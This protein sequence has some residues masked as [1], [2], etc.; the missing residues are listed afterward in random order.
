M[1]E[2]GV[3]EGGMSEGSESV[4]KGA[5]HG[6]RPHTRRWAD[7]RWLV[8][9]VIQANGIDWDQPRSV[10]L[11]APC[12]PEANA[13]FAALRA[14]VKKFA[15]A[16]PA[17]EAAARRRQ[18]KA[19]AAEAEGRPVTARENYFIAAILWGGA[20]W[21][22][23]EADETNHRYNKAKRECYRAYA[24]LADHRVEEVF[25]PFGDKVLP[26]W[27][28][29]PPGYTGGRLPTV[30]SIPGMDSF[31]EG[32]VSMYGDRFLSRGMAVLALDG[33][34]QYEAPLM[35]VFFSMENWIATGP[36]A[37]D[38]LAARPEVD[39]DRIALAG[40]SFG[41]F[42]GT[43]LTAH[44]PRIRACAV[45]ATCHEPGCQTIFEEASPTFKQ[46]F[47]FM[48]GMTDEAEFDVFRQSISWRGHAERIEV[49]YLCMAGEF[50][51]LSPIEHTRGLLAAL[52]GPK[53][54]LVYQ[55]SRH[56]VGGPAAANGPHPQGYMAD[57][58]AARLDG[59]PMASEEW[60][61]ESSGKVV[62]SPL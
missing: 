20:Q 6:K 4:A 35:D 12:G 53:Q 23:D 33:P 21:P 40:R 28:H 52:S 18:A 51:E 37:V 54:L 14:Q 58:I 38:W 41:S 29:L 7:Q 56:S 36:A 34:G 59:Q 55:G 1:G 22:I 42:F 10:Y 46:R 2:R 48:C 15:D 61:V 5:A 31:K 43:I 11:N 9:N 47:M 49:P 60:F 3:G 39:A 62:K 32:V 45:S 8:D 30:I 27:F 26:A 19:E 24:R 50:D 13:D 57:W 25:V 17:F 16:A 44:E